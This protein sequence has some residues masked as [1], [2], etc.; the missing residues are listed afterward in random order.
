MVVQ[1]PGDAYDP[2]HMAKPDP[3]ATFGVVPRPRR[4]APGDLLF[5]QGSPT[6]GVFKLVSGR[7]R[8]FRTTAGGAQATM[9][10]A[11][12]G[13]LFAEASL[14]ST[15]YHCDAEAL[16][17]SQLLLYPKAALM[18]SL[19]ETPELLWSF[20]AELARRVQGLRTR[21]E[22]Q[23]TRSARER[24]LQ[25]LQLHC[26]SKGLWLQQGT[27]KQLAD[28]LALTHEALYRTLAELERDSRIVRSERGI[29]LGPG[30]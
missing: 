6:V 20:T 28:E 21:I 14:F 23:R 25:F 13:E 5:R 11:R 16:E 3:E 30:V 29:L 17:S 2:S 9:H 26:D 10:T 7:V 24:V 12:P 4:A 22:V 1:L 27:L 8:L 19:R 18:R 15:H